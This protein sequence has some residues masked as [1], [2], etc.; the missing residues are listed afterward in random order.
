MNLT[1]SEA[2]LARVLYDRV[3]RDSP[4]FEP[5]RAVHFVAQ[6]MKRDALAV[7]HAIG[8]ERV[9]SDAGATKQTKLKVEWLDRGRVAQCPPNPDYPDGQDIDISLGAAT[10][11]EA[12]LPYPAPRCGIW[13]V[14][15]P[16][17]GLSLGFTAA[18]RIDDPRRIKVPCKAGA[19]KQ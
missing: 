6:M 9:A 5:Y 19:T 13:I 7:L 15:C 17:C 11:C 3:R 12:E 18:G 14:T 1:M 2:E 16:G 4:G 8:I 10:T